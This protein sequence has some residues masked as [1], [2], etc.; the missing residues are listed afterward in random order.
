MYVSGSMYVSGTNLANAASIIL[1]VCHVNVPKVSLIRRTDSMKCLIGIIVLLTA[2]FLAR[3]A[4]AQQASTG[5][6]PG[7]PG[8][9]ISTPSP[10]TGSVYVPNS[11][12]P[13]PG[14]SAHTN[15]VL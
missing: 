8:P 5:P 15:Y 6:A 4:L 3:G 12:Q 9:Q 13:Q 7:G 10:Q 14:S 11:S 2:L 1:E